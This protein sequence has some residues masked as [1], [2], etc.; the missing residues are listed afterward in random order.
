MAR[1]EVPE[2]DTPEYARIWNVAPHLRP[3]VTAMS[4]AIY[5]K[6]SLPIREREVAR[7]RIAQLNECHV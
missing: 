7:M 2:G 4:E 5:E 3:G 1:L 6:S